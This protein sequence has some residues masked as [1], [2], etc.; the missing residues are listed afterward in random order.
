M[1]GQNIGIGVTF[2]GIS[3][4][5][6]ITII[7]RIKRVGLSEAYTIEG[8]SGVTTGDETLYGSKMGRIR[9]GRL[10]EV[11]LANHT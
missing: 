9:L 5:V 1:P 2:A 4:P 6:Q 7:L 3:I 10:K 11:F 8:E